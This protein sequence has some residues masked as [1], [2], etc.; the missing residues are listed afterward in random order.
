MTPRERVLDAIEHREPDRV[1]IDFGGHRSSGVMAMAYAGLK[2]ALGISTGD[3]YVY[4]VVQQLAIVEP[5]VMDALNVDTVELGRSFLTD[6]ESWKDWVLPN[7]VPCKI[8][9]YVDVERR[10][11]AWYL[12]GEDSLEL[13]V[14]KDGCLYFEQCHFPLIDRPLEADS[15]ADLED[16]LGET[17]WTATAHPGAH[18]A[19]DEAGLAELADGARRLRASTD[20]AV[21]GLFGGN[22]FEIPQFLYRIDNHLANMAL[23]PDATHRLVEKLCDLHLANLEKWLGAVGPYIDVILFGDDL[24]GQNGPLIS[25]DMYRELCK[26]YHRK[27]WNRAR[28]LADVKVMLHSCGGIEPLLDDLIDAG[29]DTTNPVQITCAGMEPELLKQGYGDRLCFWGG[30]CDTRNVLPNG[31]PQQVADHVRQLVDTMS[32]GGGFVFQQV[33]NIMADVPPENVV[34]MFEAVNG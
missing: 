31:T 4:D 33:H 30:G 34:A 2:E 5:D 23:Y 14:Q 28:E 8:P 13:G 21:I 17:M 22:I 24:G 10:S 9:G 26:P 15:L 32:P 16:R 19:L 29:L 12:L 25:P 27:L 1:P 3:I 6:D 7:G 18:M 20:R 11:D